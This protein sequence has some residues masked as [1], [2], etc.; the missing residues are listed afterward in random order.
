VKV[1]ELAQAHYGMKK[2]L[3]DTSV[4]ATSQIQVEFDA[5]KQKASLM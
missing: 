2:Q 1:A 4:K 5:V 3:K